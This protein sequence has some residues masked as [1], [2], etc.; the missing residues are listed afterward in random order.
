M[1]QLV[2]QLLA[3]ITRQD[4]RHPDGFPPD[5]NGIRA[6][7]AALEDETRE[8]LEAWHSEKKPPEGRLP[9]FQWTHTRDELLQA[10]A[11]AIRTL[12]DLPRSCDC[13]DIGPGHEEGCPADKCKRF[14]D[15]PEDS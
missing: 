7:I 10:A 2:G 4:A 13:I 15:S 14:L 5:R 8:A 6:G 11:V 3:E 12:R 9:R 1:K